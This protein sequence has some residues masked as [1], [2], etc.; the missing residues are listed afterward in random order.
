MLFL[1]LINS[2]KLTVTFANLSDDFTFMCDI[3]GKVL[4]DSHT[5][6]QHNDMHS[7]C[8]VYICDHCDFA[9]INKSV[10]RE[11]QATHVGQGTL[12][13]GVTEEG[14]AALVKQ[15]A[16]N[17]DS[18]GQPTGRI[19]VTTNLPC[20]AYFSIYHLAPI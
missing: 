6:M 16:S 8:N 13:E 20:T 17:D 15:E 12:E 4:P 9:A 1:I 5:L 18:A 11:H 2:Y 7:R 3:C 14:E 10:M 19:E